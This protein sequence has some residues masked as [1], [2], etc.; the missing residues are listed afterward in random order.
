MWKV[1][2]NAYSMLHKKNY[3]ATL[4]PGTFFFFW[5]G[6]TVLE[7]ESEKCT[8]KEKHKDISIKQ[9]TLYSLMDKHTH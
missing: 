3:T 1:T 6:S 5:N 8:I 2:N 7:H 9:N 4:V